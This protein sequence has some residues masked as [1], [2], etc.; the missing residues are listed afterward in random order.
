MTFKNIRYR[1][2]QNSRAFHESQNSR[3][4][5]LASCPVELYSCSQPEAHLLPD[6]SYEKKKGVRRGRK[7]KELLGMSL[8][9]A[10][11]FRLRRRLVPVWRWIRSRRY[12]RL[13]QD[14]SPAIAPA[15]RLLWWVRSLSRR[16]RVASISCSGSAEGSKGLLLEVEQRPPPKG[17]LSVYVE[18]D[19]DDRLQRYLVPVLYF[20]HPLFGELLREAEEEFGFQHPGGITIPCPSW[21][22]ER[23]QN[24]I[25]AGHAAARRKRHGR[26]LLWLS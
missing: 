12:N 18:D 22:F 9:K 2:S 19:A 7:K 4:Q 17:Y 26:R 3:P 15:S 5:H 16:I 13:D 14:K 21:R 11:F 23:I 8:R 20:N 6:N 1:E 25:A 24:R 10:R